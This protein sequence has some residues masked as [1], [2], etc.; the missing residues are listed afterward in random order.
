MPIEGL[1][2]K[3]WLFFHHSRQDLL[4]RSSQAAA[5]P[6]PAGA[7]EPVLWKD[8]WSKTLLG[9]SKKVEDEKCELQKRVRLD[10]KEAS[11][12]EGK[13][14]RMVARSAISFDHDLEYSFAIDS[15]KKNV[16]SWPEAGLHL[17]LLA[18]PLPQHVHKKS[19][20][21]RTN[22]KGSFHFPPNVEIVS[23]LYTIETDVELEVK[24]EM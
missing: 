5:S 8:E 18:G 22:T 10:I 2:L 21:L 24:L 19:I 23:A 1:G 12:H 11:L 3:K 9:K 14:D 6:T 4:T 7:S 16:Y 20:K 15:D 17:Y 13:L